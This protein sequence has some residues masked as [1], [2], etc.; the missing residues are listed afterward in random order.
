MFAGCRDLEGRLHV[1]ST[2][3]TSWQEVT[4]YKLSRSMTDVGVTTLFIFLVP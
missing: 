3:N 4:D 1:S 2:N